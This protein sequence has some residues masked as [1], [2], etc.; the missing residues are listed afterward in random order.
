MHYTIMYISR[1]IPG[2]LHDSAADN[3]SDI[4][5]ILPDIPMDVSANMIDTHN[6]PVD[7]LSEIISHVTEGSTYKSCALVSTAWHKAARANSH[8]IEGFTNHLWTLIKYWPDKPWDWYRLSAHPLIT[9]DIVRNHMELPWNWSRVS[10]NIN[11]T[12]SIIEAHP[13]LPWD[14]QWISLNPNITTDFILSHSDKLNWDSLSQHN[15]ITGEFVLLHKD[16]PWNWMW[17]SYNPA[18]DIDSMLATLDLSW[19]RAAC[20]RKVTSIEYIRRYPDFPWDWTQLSA[21]L[22]LT[23]DIV[24][25]YELYWDWD[26]LSQ[27]DSLTPD[28]ISAYPGQPWSWYVVSGNPKMSVEFVKDNLHLPW[29]WRVL[30]ENKGITFD[31]I[32]ANKSMPW[33]WDILGCNPNITINVIKNNR[34]LLGWDTIVYLFSSDATGLGDIINEIPWKIITERDGDVSKYL[35]DRLSHIATIDIIRNN[36]S[37]PWDACSLS[38]N[39]HITA[40]YIIDNSHL[41]WSFHHLSQNN[42]KDDSVHYY[43]W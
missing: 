27:N 4:D 35:W 17:L 19:N 30:S 32:R 28:I 6:I 11:I 34:D 20:S 7:I 13:Y 25:E 43:L 31:D 1:A 9:F 42:F 36:P 26:E 33:C 15:K 38:A 18:I 41:A 39:H 21:V 40:K 3:H 8:M 37:L 2:I 29:D 22:K 16:L 5:N 23:L 14:Y 10:Q 24:Q 12:M